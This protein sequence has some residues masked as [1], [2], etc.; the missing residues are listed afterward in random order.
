[1]LLHRPLRTRTL[2]IV[3]AGIGFLLRSNTCAVAWRRRRLCR[4]CL[5]HTSCSYGPTLLKE[6][7][8]GLHDVLPRLLHALLSALFF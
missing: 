7:H 2:A 4:L 3:I 1:M 8:H 6:F 5:R